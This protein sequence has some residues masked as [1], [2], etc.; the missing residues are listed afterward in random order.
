MTKRRGVQKCQKSGSGFQSLGINILMRMLMHGVNAIG[1]VFPPGIWTF[2]FSPP[3]PCFDSQNWGNDNRVFATSR[4]WLP[5]HGH[6]VRLDCEQF[7]D[8]L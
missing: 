6:L 5:D 3:K 8:D 7:L 2:D 1:A 4:S